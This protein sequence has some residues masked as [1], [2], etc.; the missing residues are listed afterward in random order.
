M[1]DILAT[2]PAAGKS[3]VA[4]R[5]DGAQRDGANP[6][7]TAPDARYAARS[8]P[9]AVPRMPPAEAILPYLREIDAGRIYSNHGPLAR[10]LEARLA[11]RLDLAASGVATVVNATRGIT[12][13][14]QACGAAK[15]SF[16]LMPAWTF[17]ATAHA[18]VAA[19]LVPYFLDVDRGSWA[20]EPAVARAALARLPA[21]RVG[22]VVPVAPYGRPLDLA[23]WDDFEAETGV[24]V[25]IDA[26][27]GFDGLRRVGRAPVVVSMH[28]TKGFGAGEGGFVASQREE[29]IRGVTRRTNFGFLQDRSAQVPA[30]NA[31]LSEY[32]AAVGLA[33]FDAWPDT[34]AELAAAAAG[35][36]EALSGLRGLRP[37]E[38]WGTEWV[39]TTNV[40]EVEPTLANL[41]G[42][43]PAGT[44]A[45]G[46]DRHGV[47]SRR[48][49]GHGLHQE[50]AFADFPRDPLPATESLARTTLG[51]PFR[52][53]PAPQDVARIA[54][55]LQATLTDAL[56]LG[57]VDKAVPRPADGAAATALGLGRS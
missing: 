11:E 12:L 19:G 52:V 24:P 5:C 4:A 50:P 13:A 36:T 16:C 17:A 6:N 45:A 55:A 1:A 38:G 34:R 18:A 25:V 42:A 56:D 49:W 26:A 22:A 31:K 8:L 54:R 32:H 39:G 21:G 57:G 48:W 46:L 20:M 44:I 3:R 15:G 51:L 30:T 10:R 33:S 9:V 2:G 53:D 23:A 41:L 40:I 7:E 14:L 43:D 47:D 35:L 29:L 27:A 28:A 37:M